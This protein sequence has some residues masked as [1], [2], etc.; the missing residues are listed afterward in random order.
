MGILNRFTA[1]PSDVASCD[2]RALARIER[3]IASNQQHGYIYPGEQK[4]DEELLARVRSERVARQ[5]R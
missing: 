1:A 4:Q 3:D 5:S 2:D